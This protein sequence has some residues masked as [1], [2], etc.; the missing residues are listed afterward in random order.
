[1]KKMVSV[2]LLSLVIVSFLC[3]DLQAKDTDN[4]EPNRDIFDREIDKSGWVLVA[5]RVTS[6][7]TSTKNETID[8]ND[9]S[10]LHGIDMS[11]WVLTEEKVTLVETL[12]VVEAKD[13]A[14]AS[15]NNDKISSDKSQNRITEKWYRDQDGM[16]WYQWLKESKEQGKDL[17]Q[18][19]SSG[20]SKNGRPQYKQAPRKSS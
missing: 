8:N 1:M 12:S 10:T 18:E 2:V 17:W 3:F 5:E 20:M 15:V 13:N 19:Y 7:R 14:E 4:N 6:S 16:S 11:G 9:A